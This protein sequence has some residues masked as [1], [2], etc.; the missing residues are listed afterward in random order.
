M[1]SLLPLWMAIGRDVILA[2]LLLFFLILIS[3]ISSAWTVACFLVILPAFFLSLHYLKPKLKFGNFY[4]SWTLSSFVLLVGL[5]ECEVV[6]Y[7]EILMYE[8]ATV[9]FLI[10]MTVLLTI[11][12]RV[13]AGRDSL[14]PGVFRDDMTP[15]FFRNNFCPWIKCPINGNNRVYFILALIF[16]MSGLVCGSHLML[17]TICHPILVWDSILLPDDCS[18]VYS[19]SQ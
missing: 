9:V 17:T 1:S 19:D 18:E 4:L 16:N 14:S 7:T 5:F 10:L 13:K 3:S 8:N 11:F 12:V 6:P 15:R 2:P